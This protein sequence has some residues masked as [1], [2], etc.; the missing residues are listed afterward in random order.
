MS[1][2]NCAS[3]LEMAHNPVNEGAPGKVT[4]FHATLAAESTTLWLPF[5]LPLTKIRQFRIFA[6]GEKAIAVINLFFCQIKSTNVGNNMSRAQ[7]LRST[8]MDAPIMLMMI[9]IV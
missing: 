6:S 3:G 8:I 4:I 5:L 7:S 1:V 2:G 9:M